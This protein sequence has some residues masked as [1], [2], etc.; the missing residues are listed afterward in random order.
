MGLLSAF[1]KMVA[2]LRTERIILLGFLGYV[3]FGVLFLSLP[4]SQKVPVGVF[5][6]LFVASSAVSTT[7]LVT[8]SV[9]DSYT[10]F[11]QLIILIL[12][13]LGGI[14]YMA[15]GSFLVIFSGKSLSEIRRRILENE[16]P[17]P[18]GFSVGVLIKNIIAFTL[19]IEAVGAIALFLIFSSQSVPDAAWSAIF[20]S[21]SAFCTAGFGL[22]NTSMEGFYNNYAL[23][24]VILILTYIGA[25]G[26]IVITDLFYRI[27]GKVKKITFTS[28]IILFIT[29]A[30]TIAGTLI[31][32]FS[33]PKIAGFPVIDRI[34]ISLFQSVNAMT[35]A[36][37]DSF[38]IGNLSMSSIIALWFL[39]VIGASPSGTGG[40]LKTTTF[41]A[42][43]AVV[44]SKMRGGEKVAFFKHIIPEHRI[45][46][47]VTVFIAY[48]G[49]LF[50]GAFLL[51]FSEPNRDFLS[52]IFET[53]SGLGTVGL[54]M[55]ITGSLTDISKVILTVIMFIGRVGVLTFG[56]SI[57]AGNMDLQFF[58]DKS[59]NQKEDLAL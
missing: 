23:N 5:D 17:L 9:A 15:V 4:I 56:I 29:F 41:S 28:K 54:S 59:M 51:T 50:L 35:T 22:Y 44:K 40:G 25:I 47:A 11:G 16:Y 45:W 36:G 12:I 14:G 57:F 2:K 6:N 21:I 46:T 1:K 19:I 30:G 27:N 55:G 26:F 18:E 20:H 42:I 24:I 39:M 53:A 3:L 49:I 32:F 8:V 58:R 38:A 48:F 52:L 43:I 7:G 13:Q 34:F 33:E 10:F 31:I 37:F